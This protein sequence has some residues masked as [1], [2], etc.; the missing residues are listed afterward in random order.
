MKAE[1][2]LIKEPIDQSD[3]LEIVELF[4]FVCLHANLVVNVFLRLK[5][6]GRM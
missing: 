1:R 4:F 2:R 3:F 5:T 6:M